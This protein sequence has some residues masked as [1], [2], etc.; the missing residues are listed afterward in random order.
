M[1][2]AVGEGFGF[3]AGEAGAGEG[4]DEAVGVVVVG[5]VAVEVM[6]VWVSFD[7][8]VRPTDCRR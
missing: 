6:A 4:G 1:C 8:W 2:C 7:G 3:A 5:V